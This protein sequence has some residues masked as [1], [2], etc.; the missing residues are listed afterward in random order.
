MIN[1]IKRL[2][3]R[4]TMEDPKQVQ[5][6]INLLN[7]ESHGNKTGDPP[8]VWI[9]IDGYN[10]ITKFKF[11]KNGEQSAFNPNF[12]LPIKL[13]I[14]VEKGEIRIFPAGGFEKES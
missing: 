14:H 10:A 11:G 5:K 3:S 2:F 4:K 6:Q 1:F 9:A 7:K 13:F 12:G 8:D